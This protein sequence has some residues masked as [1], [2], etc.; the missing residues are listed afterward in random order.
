MKNYRYVKNIVDF[1]LSIFILLV[2]LPFIAMNAFVLAIMLR[3]NPFLIQLRGI[4]KE[5]KVFKIIKFRTIKLSAGRKSLEKNI[6]YK[7]SLEKYIP[8]YCRWL[9]KTGLDEIPQLINVMKGEMSLI[10]PRP[11]MMSDLDLLKEEGKAYYTKRN[12]LKVK[13]GI[14]GLWQTSGRREDG[15]ENLINLDAEYDEKVSIMIDVRIFVKTIPLVLRGMHSD[16]I[17]YGMSEYSS[18][19]KL[20]VDMI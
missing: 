14:T 19:V 18:S 8:A 13:P 10:G 12:T 7:P 3:A 15:F 11:L 16:A 17:I 6:F 1:V 5:N 2:L 4:T 20:D 9:R